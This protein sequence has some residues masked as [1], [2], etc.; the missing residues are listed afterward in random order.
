MID[1]CHY[2]QEE[3]VPELLL[4]SGPSSLQFPED[5]YQVQPGV[6]RFTKVTFIQYDQ[7]IAFCLRHAVGGKVYSAGTIGDAFVLKSDDN[8]RPQ[9]PRIVDAYLGH[10]TIQRKQGSTLSPD[11]NPL[12]QF[13]DDPRRTVTALN[14]PPKTLTTLSTVLEKQY[15][16]HFLQN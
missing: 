10:E 16:S 11:L 8:A 1:I 14:S 9:R 13:C 3:I 5:W 4:N 2:A 15:N 6:E 7:S 12:E